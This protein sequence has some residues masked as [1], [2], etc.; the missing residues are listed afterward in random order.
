KPEILSDPVVQQCPYAHYARLR[1]EAPVRYDPG[2]KAHVV[3]SYALALQVLSDF[4]TFSN[5]PQSEQSAA[6]VINATVG[7]IL[8]E[9]GFGRFKRTV[10]NN[11]PPSHGYYRRLLNAAFRPARIRS[12]EP[13]IGT[14]VDRLIG[15]LRTDQPCEVMSTFAVPLPLH[16]ISDQIGIPP[17]E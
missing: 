12:M 17:A 8:K 16:I 7:R 6:V 9:Q 15:G 10:V 5:L 1:A 3:S 11:D 14:V 4:R 2:V 13:Y